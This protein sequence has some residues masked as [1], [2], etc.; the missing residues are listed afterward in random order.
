[1]TRSYRIIGGI[2]YILSLIPFVTFVGII[3]TAIAWIMAGGDT[4]QGVFKAT[5]ILMIITLIASVAM[6]IIAP[7]SIPFLGMG[8]VRRPAALPRLSSLLGFVGIILAIAIIVSV[9]AFVTFILELI[10]HFRAASVYENKWFKWGG[11]LRI[12]GI[13][14]LVIMIPVIF[15]TAP[16]MITPSLPKAGYG[17]PAALSGIL[18]L[19][20]IPGIVILIGVIFSAV[21]FFTIPQVPAE[22]PQYYRP[23]PPPPPPSEY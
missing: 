4:R 12:I 20:L 2:G 9:I 5:G 15:F 22:Q 3:L 7:F 19:V 23:P 18:G 21:A 8:G 17:I 10:S 1:M 6:I 11:W 14:L 13:I 16:S